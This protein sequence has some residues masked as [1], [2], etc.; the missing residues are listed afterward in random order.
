MIS[1]NGGCHVCGATVIWVEHDTLGTCVGKIWKIQLVQIFLN[2][3]AKE[4]GH[5]ISNRKSLNLNDWLGQPHP[6]DKNY[7]R[8]KENLA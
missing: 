6:R 7:N 5:F 1:G 4:F 2:W 3:W 8:R